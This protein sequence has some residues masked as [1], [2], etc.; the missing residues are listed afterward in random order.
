MQ[1]LTSNE[2]TFQKKLDSCA[3]INENKGG[4]DKK[5]RE[6]KS[7]RDRQTQIETQ[8]ERTGGGERE[9]DALL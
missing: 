6:S 8:T 5:E 7:G 1:L 4:G 9:N 3:F 2:I